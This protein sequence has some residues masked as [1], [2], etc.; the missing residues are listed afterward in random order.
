MSDTS[1]PAQRLEQLEAR[2]TELERERDT[3]IVRSST[4]ERIRPEVA[5][6]AA[7]AVSMSDLREAEEQLLELD[8][9]TRVIAN[10]TPTVVASLATLSTEIAEARR[11]SNRAMVAQLL[12]DAGPD[13]D[14]LLSVLDDLAGLRRR[15]VEG[16]APDLLLAPAPGQLLPN[17]RSD[18]VLFTLID[19]LAVYLRGEWSDVVLPAARRDAGR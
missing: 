18:V 3:M 15:A 1:T 9:E 11:G 17:A 10:R 8:R 16:G 5:Q 4:I 6:R 2:R 7:V 12:V 14:R 13:F 19:R